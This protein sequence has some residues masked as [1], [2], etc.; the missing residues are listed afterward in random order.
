MHQLQQRCPAGYPIRVWH[1]RAGSDLGN[2][3][4]V[5]FAGIRHRQLEEEAIQLGLR[6]GVR[7]FHLDRILR[8]ENEKGL[9]ERVRGASSR[10]ASLLHRLEQ[11][12]LGLG[13]RAVNLV[14]EHQVGKQR[15]R[16]ELE[17]AYS[18]GGIAQDAG[19][20]DVSRHQVGRELHP[21]KRQVERLADG[22][23]QERLAKAGNAFEQRVAASQQTR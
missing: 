19:A 10:H 12:R 1:V 15:P 5:L 20:S 16:L 2:A 14:S 6:Q 13:C 22:A 21:A 17:R 23:H 11:G 7:A 18:V 9:R 8:G 4:E 3:Q